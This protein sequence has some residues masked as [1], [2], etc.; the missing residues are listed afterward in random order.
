MHGYV[1]GVQRGAV[2]VQ[3]KI[4]NEYLLKAMRKKTSVTK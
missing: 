2:A 4:V 3:K 1:F